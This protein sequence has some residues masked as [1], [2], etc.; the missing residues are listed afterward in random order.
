M[1]LYIIRH[2]Q[3]TNNAMED[4]TQRSHDPSLT[5]LGAQQARR[6]AAW[7]AAGDLRIPWTDPETGY[8]RSDPQPDFTFDH[9]YTSAMY[10]ALQTA[11]PLGQA[12]HIRPEIWIDI[13]EHGGIY[14]EQPDG[15]IGYGGKT[16]SEIL[17]EFADYTLPDTLTDDGW[18][19]ATLGHEERG[20]FYG[21]AIRVAVELRQRAENPDSAHHRIA[22]VTHG[23]FIDALLKA[24]LNMLPSRAFFFLHYNTAITRLDFSERGMLVRCINRVD[25]LPADMI[26]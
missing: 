8:T 5:D 21:R 17:S 13:H 14:L 23:T 18:W 19:N 7:F 6:L 4:S 22:I 16:R 3:S 9:L 11:A 26:S 15:I 2:G 24:F 12:L 25:H 1:E 20:A 10:R